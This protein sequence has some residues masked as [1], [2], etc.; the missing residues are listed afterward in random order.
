MSMRELQPGDIVYAAT[1]IQSDG[2]V[3][4]YPLDS[5]IAETGTRGVIVNVGHVEEDPDTELMLVRFEDK[6]RELGPPVGC[7]LEELTDECE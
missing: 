5:I 1:T 6:D 7:W 2:A 4:G 3:P